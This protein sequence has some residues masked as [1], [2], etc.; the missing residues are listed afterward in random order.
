MSKL[1]NE[2]AVPK[3][4]HLQDLK[5]QEIM[6]SI[7]VFDAGTFKHERNHQYQPDL[8]LFEKQAV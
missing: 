8:S 2:E 4:A 3:F 5:K 7:S 6:S 1:S